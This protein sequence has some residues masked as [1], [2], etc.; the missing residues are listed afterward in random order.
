MKD[1]HRRT[2]RQRR[3]ILDIVR[4]HR[5][6]PTAEEIYDLVRETLP[7]TSLST[8]YRNLGVLVD[9]NEIMALRSSGGEVRYDGCTSEHCHFSCV[10]CGR[11]YDLNMDTEYFSNL[12]AL[13]NEGFLVERVCVGF[14]G[15]C[16]ET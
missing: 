12:K 1:I 10:N 5:G 2:T 16:P 13:D 7:R 15:I 8:V 9:M 4:H 3:L 14:S 6:H 11:L